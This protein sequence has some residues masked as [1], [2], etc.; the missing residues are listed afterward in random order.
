MAQSGTPRFV[1]SHSHSL[2]A[3]NRLTV[4]SKWRFDGDDKDG[5]LAMPNPTL[6]CI[7]LYPPKKVEQMEERMQELGMSDPHK[8]KAAMKLFSMSETVTCDK[9]GRINL[10][11]TLT[12]YAG[13]E[14]EALLVGSM[15]SINIWKPERYDDYMGED[16][17]TDDDYAAALR[18]LG[19]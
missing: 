13:V 12:K 16:N 18:E 5:F 2:D 7:T 14:K 6:K 3:K 10:P 15:S 11:L 1:G 17:F 4:P 19:V 8:Q 9:Q